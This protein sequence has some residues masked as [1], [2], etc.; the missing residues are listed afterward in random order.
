MSRTRIKICGITRPQDAAAAVAAGADAVGMVFHV[1][2]ARGITVEQAREIAAQVPAFVQLVGLFVDAD[3]L[4]IRDV[5]RQV[6]LSAV[7][8]SGHESPEVVARLQ[9]IPVIKSVPVDGIRL[10]DLLKLWK[11]AIAKLGLT[12]LAGLLMETA[13]TGVP[14][15]SGV[16]NDFVAIAEAQKRGDFTGLPP[17]IIAGGLHPQN[18]GE[19][20]KLLK[21]YAVD[22]SSG[23]EGLVKG[24]KLPE[25]IAT[26]VKAVAATSNAERRMP[27]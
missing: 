10:S 9:P 24:Q 12:N 7:Q 8:L 23:V 13:G 6:H 21:P 20:V 15:G 17:I 4:A 18:V 27:N 11:D 19:V 25:K 26:F 16:V 14:G 5:V 3:P 22:V 2:A 1:G